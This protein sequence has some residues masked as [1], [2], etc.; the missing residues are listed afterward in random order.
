M[1]A[2][3]RVANRVRLN[4]A[5]RSPRPV[6]VKVEVEGL[7]GGQV[8]LQPNPMRLA[9]PNQPQSQAV[10]TFNVSFNSTGQSISANL[11]SGALN[12]TDSTGLAIS[13]AYP[14]QISGAFSQRKTSYYAVN[15]LGRIPVQTMSSYVTL[16]SVY[17]GSAYSQNAT[18]APLCSP[19][20]LYSDG[21][22]S[23]T[24]N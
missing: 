19:T 14:L 13:A 7:P 1:L 3:G 9:T 16:G 24:S 17:Q 20:G 2:D 10:W 12:Y 15:M 21:T 23:C 22:S 6:D 5:N 8:G 18:A 4:L 11:S